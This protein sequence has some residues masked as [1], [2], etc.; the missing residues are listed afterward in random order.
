[1]GDRGW[2][3]GKLRFAGYEFSALLQETVYHELVIGD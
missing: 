2:V 3:K 1:M